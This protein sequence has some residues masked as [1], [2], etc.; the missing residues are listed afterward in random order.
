[1]PAPDLTAAFLAEARKT[2]RRCGGKITHCLA[3]LS[4]DDVNWRP[5]AEANSIA[6]IVAHLCGNVGQWIVAG[7]GGAPDERDRP[8]EFARDLR[9]TPRELAAMLDETLRRADDAIAAVTPDTILAPRR[10]QGFDETALSAIFH[11]TSHFEGHTHQ[12]VYITR[13][14]LGDRYQFKWVPSTP[15]QVSGKK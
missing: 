13:L 10:I 5:F 12:V 2:L 9:S 15:E 4:D 11:T 1:M 3:Q 8:G 6:N 14:R 7:V